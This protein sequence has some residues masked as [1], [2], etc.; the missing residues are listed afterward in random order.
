MFL[1]RPAFL[2]AVNTPLP[3]MVTVSPATTSLELPSTLAT[4]VPS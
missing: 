4:A 3:L 1:A 2:P